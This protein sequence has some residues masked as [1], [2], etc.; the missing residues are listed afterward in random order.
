MEKDIEVGLEDQKD[1]KG[2]AHLSHTKSKPEIAAKD[3]DEHHDLHAFSTARS[4]YISLS[5]VEPVDVQVRDLAV[6]VDTSPSIFSLSGL[7]PRK[8][9]K[10]G[11]PKS[12]QK[13]ILY[14]ASASM[15][16]GTLTAIIG[17][18]GSGKTTML[19]TMAERMT[20]GRISNEGTAK[21]NGMAGI[22]SIRSAY[23]VQTDC[24]LPTLT[25]REILRFSADLRLPPPT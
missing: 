4:N 21:F 10:D 9:N 24:L 12:E 8:R 18:S 1:S 13:R 17:G 20:G 23:V 5:E 6:S 3:H 7:L 19:N 16:A 2:A 22:N 11:E 25:P 14:S 15:P